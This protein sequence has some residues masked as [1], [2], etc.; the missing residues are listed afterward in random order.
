MAT[1]NDSLDTFDCLLGGSGE[2]GITELARVL[3][4]WGG[5]GHSGVGVIDRGLS[6]IAS[7]ASGG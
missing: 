3:G 1:C 4:D 5:S 2:P 7:A 6:S